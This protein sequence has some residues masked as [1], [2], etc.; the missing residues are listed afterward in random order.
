MGA[1]IVKGSVIDDIPLGDEVQFL[2]NKA[3]PDQDPDLV[4]P[5]ECRGKK[6]EDGV[7]FLVLSFARVPFDTEKLRNN[8]IGPFTKPDAFHMALEVAYDALLKDYQDAVC[9]QH[10]SS[11]NTI[12]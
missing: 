8:W 7:Y 6:E 2:V 3:R 4:P 12:H 11:E 9:G 5:M 10:A 1:S